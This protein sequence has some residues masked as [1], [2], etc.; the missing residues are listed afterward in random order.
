MCGQDIAQGIGALMAVG[1]FIGFSVAVI[2]QYFGV[3][4][5]AAVAVGVM[6]AVLGMTI[7]YIVGMRIA[8]SH[9]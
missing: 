8:R 1:A 4:E 2:M 7:A 3:S 9:P 5:M 6:I